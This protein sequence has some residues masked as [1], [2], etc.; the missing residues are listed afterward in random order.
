M[1]SKLTTPEL[2]ELIHDA[3]DE[4]QDRFMVIYDSHEER[5]EKEE[6]EAK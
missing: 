4:L 2:I 5:R 3:L 1:F 6:A